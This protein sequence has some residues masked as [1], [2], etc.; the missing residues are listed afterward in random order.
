MAE[1]QYGSEYEKA[2]LTGSHPKK[3]D[4]RPLEPPPY[5]ES[6]PVGTFLATRWEE[7]VVVLFLSTVFM[8]CSGVY[9]A[10]YQTM[11]L[12]C[13]AWDVAA[14]TFAVLNFAPK[15]VRKKARMPLYGLTMAVVVARF[16]RPSLYPSVYRWQP[17]QPV[18]LQ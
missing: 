16:L 3:T 7:L 2:V 12:L 15:G 4:F 8:Y 9:V 17:A 14:I 1:K 10:A 11:R 6:S 5:I 13:Y 18:E